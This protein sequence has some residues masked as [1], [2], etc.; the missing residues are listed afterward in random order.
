[1]KK[2]IYIFIL[3]LFSMG[4]D[5]FLEE[6]TRGILS[7]DGFYATE[8]QANAG[9]FGLYNIVKSNPIYGR[10]ILLYTTYGTDDMTSSRRFGDANTLLDASLSTSN[11]GATV[12][13]WN[14]LHNLVVNANSVF[15]G[16]TN[17]DLSPVIKDRILAE[18]I[19]LRSVGYYHLTHM[20]GSV[21]Y[22]TEDL[23]IDELAVLGETSAEDIVAELVS[24][25]KATEDNLPTSYPSSEAI[26]ATRWAAKTLRMKL[27]LWQNN[28]AEA[29]VVGKD[30]INNSGLTLEPNFA[31]LWDNDVDGFTSETIWQMIYA[32]DLQTSPIT[33]FYVPRLRDEPADQAD[34]QALI[35]AL[36]ANGDGFTGFGL[37]IPS[38]PFI[39]SLAPDDTRTP[40]NFTQE[41]EGIALKFPYTPKFQN[42]DQQTSPRFNH[43]D[44][45]VVFRLADVYLMLAE[46]LNEQN[47]GD[48][49]LTFINVVRARAYEPDRPNLIGLDQAA[50]KQVISDERRWE[51]A[52]EG[53]R[54]YDLIRWGTYIET[55]RNYDYGSLWDP[56]GIQDHQVLF[57]LSPTQVELTPGL[58]QTPGY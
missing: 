30:I 43:R 15:T 8:A 25:L 12:G 39:A 7:P 19:F 29:E 33:D 18:T 24:D 5:E 48:E 22:H 45:T 49:A 11:L 40:L 34:R 54:R 23:P 56:S 32:F 4:C 42:F 27:L 47:K 53:H 14:N 26:R 50:I 20:F 44:N 13:I 31:D 36:N 28:W 17:S 37:L 9:V 55:V 38:D 1:M 58:Q 41:Y 3:I 16:V 6:D 57:P 35:D 10:N 51:L 2:Y 46:A 52:G 21:P